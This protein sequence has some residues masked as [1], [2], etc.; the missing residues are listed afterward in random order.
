MRGIPARYYIIF[1]YRDPSTRPSTFHL[2]RAGKELATP[3]PPASH[4]DGVSGRNKK[5]APGGQLELS[6]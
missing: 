5:A 2:L 6:I 3:A 4:S 1:R